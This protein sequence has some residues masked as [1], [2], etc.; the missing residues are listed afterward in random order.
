VSGRTLG[1]FEV[2]EKPGE[3]GMGVVYKAR[4]SLLHRFVA[5]KVLESLLFR[6]QH[7]VL[8][9]VRRGRRAPSSIELEHLARRKCMKKCPIISG[10][11][12]QGRLMAIIERATGKACGP[13]FLV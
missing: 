3:G 5:L 9:L 12:R 8:G 10:G 2:L 1:H 11:N 6:L 13:S 4:D 7:K